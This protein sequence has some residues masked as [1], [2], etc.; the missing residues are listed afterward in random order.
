MKK[1][2]I[3]K[4]YRPTDCG[5]EAI[6]IIKR[7]PCYLFVKNETGVEWRMRIKE[8]DDCEFLTDSTLPKRWQFAFTYFADNETEIRE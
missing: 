7:T 5:F 8:S 2:E 3:G 6:Q 1:F 4:W